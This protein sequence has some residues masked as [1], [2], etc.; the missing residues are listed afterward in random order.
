MD[1][2]TTLAP[3]LARLRPDQV[4][5]VAVFLLLVGSF[6][7]Y[8]PSLGNEFVWDDLHAAAGN[9]GGRR[10]PLVA[11]LRPFGDYLL[12]NWWPQRDPL[13]H[14][15]RPLTTFAFALRHAIFGDQ[16]R[17]AH[18]LNVLL[19][20]LGV[21][22]CLR[23]LLRLGVGFAAALLGALVFAMHAIHSETVTN[24]VGA[25]E[26]QAFAAG[27][28]GTLCLCAPPSGVPWRQ[29]ARVVAAALWF[30]AAYFS[31]ESALAWV[32]FAPMCLAAARMARGEAALGR[33]SAGLGVVLAVTLPAVLFLLL[34]ARM[35]AHLPIGE[36]A[37]TH[38]DNP[39]VGAPTITRLCTALLVW[40]YG[41]G[42]TLLPLRLRADYGPA[43][44]PIVDGLGDPWI[45]G[46][47]AATAALVFVAAQLLF[48]RRRPLLALA[49][50][51]F[52]G[53]SFIISNVPTATFM[54]FAERVY[55]T[56]SLG[57]ALL[58]AWIAE[59]T[60]RSPQGW[61]IAVLLIGAWMGASA[62][63]A[64]QRNAFW[65]DD[66]TIIRLGVVEAP[67]SIRL[68]LCAGVAASREGDAFAAR[69]HFESAIG[70]D[71]R[72]PQPWLE[73]GNLL[74]RGGDRDGATQAL[75]HA[76]RGYPSDVERM[77]E[78]LRA[79]E[80]RLAAATPR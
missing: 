9:G 39:L 12:G 34:R 26:L 59:R 3:P 23:L 20:T 46:T 50:A 4:R 65:A 73:L 54:L 32:V 57:A 58:V 27:V 13:C 47:I 61:P 11:E 40:G 48:A 15:Y 71:P 1:S 29:R 43:Q 67:N 49:A 33:R 66:A 79:L 42:L 19:H 68:H 70:L 74:L 30:T 60:R 8:A 25:A 64:W 28:A 38:L 10:N 75:V 69:R 62:S 44:L 55:F 6:V 51:A 77:G 17:V 56:P 63:A 14:T 72:A 41:L 52:L 35:I 2:S 16:A 18:M 53:F 22:L 5:A 31:K 21:G 37:L 80:A 45:L 24:I 76:R 7:L 78:D 36:V